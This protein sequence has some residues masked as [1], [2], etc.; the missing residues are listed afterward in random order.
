MSSSLTQALHGGASRGL[1]APDYN[2]I[3]LPGLETYGTS[4]T[5]MMLFIPASRYATMAAAG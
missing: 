1:P 4:G 5:K 3:I 2:L